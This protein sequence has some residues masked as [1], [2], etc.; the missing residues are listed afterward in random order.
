MM[1]IVEQLV[2]WKLAE[3]IEVLWE[4]LPVSLYPPQIP[5]AQIRAQTRAGEVENQR[6]TTWTVAQS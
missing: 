4:N 1:V 2:E 6:L 5:Y 3:K